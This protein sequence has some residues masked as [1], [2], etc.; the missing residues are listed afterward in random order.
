VLP[1]AAPQ[2][3]KQE[4]QSSGQ[5]PQ[6]SPPSQK[7]LGQ[8]GGQTPQSSGQLVQLSLPSHAPLPQP[9]DGM[10]QQVAQSEDGSSG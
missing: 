4:P 10:K 3:G 1:P 7:P 8:P 5:V 2:L 9:T 6:V